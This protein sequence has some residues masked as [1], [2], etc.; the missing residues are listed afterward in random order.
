MRLCRRLRLAFASAP[1]LVR[2]TLPHTLTHRLIMQ[3]A[4]GHRNSTPKGVARLPQLVSKRFQVLFHSPPGVL[5]T[6]PS[7]YWFTIGRQRILSLE[8]WSSRIPTGFL[9]SR[10]TWVSN[11]GSPRPFA[12]GT[13]TRYGRPSQ[14]VR[15]ELGFV[16]P[17]PGRTPVRLDPIT[18]AAQ[19]HTGFNMQLGLG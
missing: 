17:R 1:R 8:R 16:T 11:P 3:K 12:Y 4:R 10:G 2:L 6:F 14:I 9:V 18:P 15:L 7:R 19:R 13:L 5:F